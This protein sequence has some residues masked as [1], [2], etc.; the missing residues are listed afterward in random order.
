MMTIQ[1]QHF[2]HT[3]PNTAT[4]AS[5]Y[6]GQMQLGVFKVDWV[7]VG[8]P[9]GVNGVVGFYIASSHVQVVPF[10]PGSST[11]WVVSNDRV[12]HWDLTDQPDSGDWQ[13]YAYNTGGY[14]HTLTVTW[15]VE[16]VGSGQAPPVTYATNDQLSNA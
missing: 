14:S 10:P 7:E 8:V 3:I 12:F 4:T 6:V 16:L 2:A 11:V 13:F 15:G 1:V 5:P 9:D